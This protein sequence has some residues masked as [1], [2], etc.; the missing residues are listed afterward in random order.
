M[1]YIILDFDIIVAWW[2]APR[3]IFSSSS[4]C[5]EFYWFSLYVWQRSNVTHNVIY[6]GSSWSSPQIQHHQ[7][8]S[9]TSGPLYNDGI[10]V[11]LV[12]L[13]NARTQWNCG[14][15]EEVQFKEQNITEQHPSHPSQ[16]SRSWKTGNSEDTAYHE[17]DMEINGQQGFPGN[18]TRK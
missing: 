10:T 15:H 5:E 13:T 4:M 12:F 18:T 11:S 7:K 16:L 9:L 3:S 1:W 2:N 8:Y 6:N 14:K 17:S